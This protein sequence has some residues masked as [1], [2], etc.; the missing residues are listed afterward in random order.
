MG[1]G[2]GMGIGGT[3]VVLILSLLFGRNLFQDGGVSGDPTTQTAG[4]DVAPVSETAEERERFDLVNAVVNDIQPVWTDILAKHGAQYRDAK[5]VVFRNATQSACGVGQ[6]AMGPFYC[7]TDERVYLDLGF[8]EQLDTRLGAAG[9]FAQ[10]YVIAHEIGHH[11]QHI[12]GTD[13]QVRQ[14]QEQRPNEANQLSVRLELQA[15]CFAGVWGKSTDQRRILD[16]GDIEEGLNAAAAIGDDK[17]SG[18]R[19]RPESF[20]HGSSK[21][22]ES[23]FRRGFESGDPESCNTFAGAR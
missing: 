23:W 4:G 6:S 14:R 7:P 9:D 16:P 11:V 2:G 12:L 17:L 22:R 13:A 20:T 21:E 10:A 1:L 18:G 19:V 5:V 15:D 3:V 8:F